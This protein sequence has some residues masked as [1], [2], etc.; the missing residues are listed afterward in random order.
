MGYIKGLLKHFTSLYFRKK[1]IEN[2][3]FKVIGNG[4]D[5]KTRI[6][7]FQDGFLPKK[8]QLST[9]AV[10]FGIHGIIKK[11]KHI[12]G[13]GGGMKIK[14]PKIIPRAG[15]GFSIHY[16]D[17]GGDGTKEKYAE[18]VY[19]SG[20]NGN[21]CVETGVGGFNDIFSYLED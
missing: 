21:F 10:C 19:V 15:D 3:G 2:Y 18:A 12:A 17:S 7:V 8:E 9:R 11:W 13:T 6:K 14:T 4:D 1:L 5:D 16:P 20:D